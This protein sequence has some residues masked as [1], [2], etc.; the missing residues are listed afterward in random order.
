M[1]D[2][3]LRVL[4]ITQWFDPEPAFKGLLFAQ[5]LRKRGLDVRVLTGFPNYPGG[6]VYPGYRIRPFT[7]EILDGIQVLRVALFPSHDASGPRRALNYLSF[8]V[9][10][11]IGVLCVRRPDVAYVYHPPATVGVPAMVL[12]LLRGVPFVYDVQDMW[13]ESLKATGMVNSPRALTLVGHLLKRIYSASTRIVVQSRGFKD[14][15]VE[16]AVPASRI[17]VIPN[18]A[19]EENISL[20]SPSASRAAELGFA[21][22]FTVTFAGNMGPA[23]DLETVLRA[24]E[25]LRTENGIRFL[26]VGG[27]LELASLRR[28]ATERGLVNV[29]FMDRRPVAEIG[30]ILALSDALLVHLRDDPLFAITVPSKTQAYLLAGR[31]IVMAVRGDAARIIE[32]SGAGVTCDPGNPAALA[33]AVRTLHHLG[34]EER[35]AMGRAG[36]AYYREHLAV[37]SGSAR[38]VTVRLRA[39]REKSHRLL[40]K[41]AGDVIASLVGLGVLS[42]PLGALALLVRRHLGSPVIFTQTRPGR[43]GV[44]FQIFK[45]RT[46]TNARGVNGEL[47]PDADRLTRFGS[48][49]RATSLDELP[50]LWN[51]LRG[52]M[53]LVGPRPLLM[54]YTEFFTPDERTRLDMRPGITG[55]A[56]IHGRNTAS[57]D[58]RLRR[59]AWYVSHFSPILDLK[60]LAHTLLQVVRRTGVVVDQQSM[61]L[62]LDDIRRSM[63]T[64]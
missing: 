27:G 7:R 1:R 8:A 13:P 15:L 49:L 46:M 63:M 22:M 52:D 10:A 53:S 36:H 25:L 42:I 21:G 30:E 9:S 17:E 40:L 41:R 14:T 43:D 34:Q 47:L 55:L 62:N 59:D 39:R 5:E 29:T 6:Q 57:W 26:L 20:E 18:W 58:D 38:F 60:I 19:D 12:K 28:H 61:M 3:P 48:L 64:D 37:S 51:V 16:R 33:D 31:P 32:E 54:R 35:D 2:R 4:L 44:P 45:F 56:Q 11:S 50:E 24:A 23:Q